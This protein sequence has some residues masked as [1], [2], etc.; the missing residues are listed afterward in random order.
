MFAEQAA[1]YCHKNTNR[2]GQQSFTTY[3][4]TSLYSIS[5]D[6]TEKKLLETTRRMRKLVCH[7]IKT[8]E[9]ASAFVYLCYNY[10]NSINAQ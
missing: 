1:S 2:G 4:P 8:S 7:Y 6:T 3:N 9:G 5:A 10:A